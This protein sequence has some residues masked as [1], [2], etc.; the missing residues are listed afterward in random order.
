MACLFVRCSEEEIVPDGAGASPESGTSGTASANHAPYAG[1]TNARPNS[2]PANGH[3]PPRMA[4]WGGLDTLSAQHPFV[5]KVFAAMRQRAVHLRR[6]AARGTDF[7]LLHIEDIRHLRV[8]E[9][10]WVY[11]PF[12]GHRNGYQL[13]L[14]ACLPSDGSAVRIYVQ[15][16]T[17]VEQIREGVPYHLQYY[18]LD[19]TAI[20]PHTASP[21]LR[22]VRKSGCAER[23]ELESTATEQQTL[24]TNPC[25]G[26]GGSSSGLP[27]LVL[28][29]VVVTAPRYKPPRT[30]SIPRIPF[31]PRFPVFPPRT[32]SYPSL[33]NR[34]FQFPRRAEGGGGG[35]ATRSTPGR[36][37]NNL[38][39]KPLCVYNRLQRLSGGF[40]SAI[41]RFDGQ[42][43]VAHLRLVMEDLGNKRAVTRPPNNYVIEVAF[44]NNSSNHGVSYRPN[45]LIV[46]TIIHEIIHAEMFR[47]L[48]SLSNRNGSIDVRRLNEMLQNGDY[49]GIFDYYTRYGRNGFQHQQMATHYRQTIANILQEYDTGRPVPDG[50]QPAQLYMDLAWEGL[51]HSNIV[52]W[53]RQSSS[54]KMRIR[55]VISNYINN[56]RNESCS[57]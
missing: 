56:N 41:Q 15:E 6:A 47:K 5:D 51:N 20:R 12:T 29:P 52:A 7:R 45:L 16:T 43:P 17:P 13:V 9:Q 8:G 33:N 50:Q 10:D 38:T 48:I 37:I 3:T 44:N 54:E 49:P 32:P 19:M 25:G 21:R 26:G 36:I 46:K 11:I 23:T 28:R 2:E 22:N 39:G 24:L 35:G 55:G 18:S 4:T 34:G 57:Q 30:F 14:A 1:D 53:T 40:R 31:I 27:T 42:F